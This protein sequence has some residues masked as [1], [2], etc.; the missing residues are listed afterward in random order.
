MYMLKNKLLLAIFALVIGSAIKAQT[1]AIDNAKFDPGVGNSYSAG[2]SVAIPLNNSGCFSRT[3]WFR[4]ELMDATGTNLLNAT[5]GV[6]ANAAARVADSTKVFY[7][8]FVNA[9][10]PAT[11]PTGTYTI[12]VS[13][14][15]TGAPSATTLPFAVNNGTAITAAAVSAFTTFLNVLYYR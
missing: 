15:T 11:L 10:L 7:A 1:I 2:G 3:N 12:R 8:T 5:G 13:A 6:A 14:T 9:F 4:W